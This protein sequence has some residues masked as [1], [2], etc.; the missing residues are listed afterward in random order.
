[1]K[2]YFLTEEFFNKYSECQEMEK[3]QDRPYANVCLVKL[4]NLIFAIPIRSNIKHK[5]AVYS[6]KERNK[7]LDLSKTVLIVNFKKYVD[8]KTVVTINKDEYK[9]LKNKEKYIEQKLLSYINMYK[10]ALKKQHIKQNQLLCSMS[11]LQYFHK[12]LGIEE[13]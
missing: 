10:K 7:G 3:K 2:F 11:C 9:I 13:I 5:Y 6:N 1:M 4:N 12:E 8:I